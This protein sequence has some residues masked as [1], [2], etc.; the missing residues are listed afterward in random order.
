MNKENTITIFWFRRDLRI[1]GNKGL[2]VALKKYEQ[3]LPIFIFDPDSFGFCKTKSDIRYSFVYEQLQSIN[4]M[5]NKH[6]SALQIFYGNTL[7]TFIQL[8]DK[9]KIHAIIANADY[10]PHEIKRDQA[11]SQFAKQHEIAF[12][13][14]HTH[15][16]YEPTSILKKD[17]TPY[18]IFTPY[19]KKWLE[20]F[21][22]EPVFKDIEIE[23]SHFSSVN[24]SFATPKQLQ[25]QY[26]KTPYGTPSID[27]EMIKN[28][29]LT[30][31]FPALDATS[32][33]SIHLRWGT[34]DIQYVAS[35]AKKL[36]EKFLNE[37]IWREFYKMIL[38]YF[39]KSITYSFKTKYDNISWVNDKSD[40][41]KWCSGNTG[42]PIVDAGMRQLNESGFMHNRVRMITASFLC[43]HLLIDWRWG[44]AYFAEKLIDYD[45]S[46]N[47]GGWQWAA[48]SG[49]DPVPYFRIF[50]PTLQT[51]KYDAK[52]LYIKK[53]IKEWG[54]DSYAKP[55]VNH[56]FARQRCLQTYKK[57][58]TTS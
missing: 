6:G 53:W 8:K 34:I 51:K 46:A 22:K 10:E 44:E 49:C 48:G 45:A 58:L 56:E 32:K 23:Y 11:I 17:G 42:Y 1:K 16:I 12:E 36:N 30:R 39:P 37:L 2:S 24:E 29:H 15:C 41:E 31:D 9:Y 52:N 55:M 47:V 43:K 3:V 25:F 13:L 50:N 33:L 19:S 28:Y 7:N 26:F 27:K 54:T 21:I 40:Y 35:L 57:A 18:T 5:L 4:S 14:H 38:F 20:K